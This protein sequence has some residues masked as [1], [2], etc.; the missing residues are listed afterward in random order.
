MSAGHLPTICRWTPG[1]T[2]MQV[3]TLVSINTKNN[4]VS[5]TYPQRGSQTPKNPDFQNDFQTTLFFSI[6]LDN[7]GQVFE[8]SQTLCK[9]IPPT[10]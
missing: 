9:R 8:C 5:K 1:N 4:V 3:P 2:Y 7:V 6:Y 10:W